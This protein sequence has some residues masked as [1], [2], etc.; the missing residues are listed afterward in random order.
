MGI[1]ITRTIICDGC[2]KT[3]EPAPSL[4]FQDCPGDW[5]SITRRHDGTIT[6]RHYCPRCAGKQLAAE[7][8]YADAKDRLQQMHG[9][10][11]E[12]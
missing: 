12:A 11:I 9:G 10:E 6:S 4:I 2:G 8:R 7:G 1:V 5:Y 3:G